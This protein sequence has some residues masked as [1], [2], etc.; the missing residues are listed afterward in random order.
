MIPP[1]RCADLIP[2]GWSDGV[3]AAAVP[4][5][6][7][8][9]MGAPLTPQIVAAI[10]APWASAYVEQDSQIDKA[11]GRTADT[12]SIV[13]ECEAQANAARPGK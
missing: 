2:K 4:D 12:I 13:R 1:A 9:V 5:N 7:P 3:P 6:A 10:I 8:V 11:N